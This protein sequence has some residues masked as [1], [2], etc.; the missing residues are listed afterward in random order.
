V[1]VFAAA[2]GG[3]VTNPV[4]KRSNMFALSPF[5]IP[6]L[7]DARGRTQSSAALQRFIAAD[8][9][10]VVFQPIFHARSLKVFA[11]E[12]L[13][14]CRAPEFTNPSKL[15]ERAAA[16]G[17]VGR[18]GRMVR[19]IA[20]PNCAGVPLFLNL[21]P[22]E[23]Q[24]RWL[25]QPDDPMFYHDSDVY[26]EV[27]ESVP[28][29]HYDLCFNVIREVR[30]RGPFFLVVDDLGAGYSNLKRIADL[31]P[32]V[33]K[34]DRDLIA[35]LTRNSRQQILVKGVVDLCVS[36][37]AKVVA[38]GIE[39]PEEFAALRETGIHFVQGYLFAR[40]GFPAPPLDPKARSLVG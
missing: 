22:A 25:V 16:E 21:H 31:E 23:L 9:L 20:V 10:S 12:A 29:T 17:C 35:G 38:E 39:T 14:R 30:S 3:G 2:R 8:D 13:V 7:R 18:L 40:P 1:A 19:E 32:H 24:Q 27:T 26:L 4:A 5:A 11:Y 36:L 37:G 15:F 6:D 28:L 33:V 34:L